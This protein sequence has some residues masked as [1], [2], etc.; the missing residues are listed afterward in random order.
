M[1][2]MMALTCISVAAKMVMD[3]D[4]YKD[5]ELLRASMRMGDEGGWAQLGCRYLEM[6]HTYINTFTQNQTD[7]YT[8]TINTNNQ[9]IIKVHITPPHEAIISSGSESSS[10]FSFPLSF[11]HSL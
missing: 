6:I 7:I 9:L 11:S 8:H 1:I 2:T 4:L 3:G 10:S 5:G